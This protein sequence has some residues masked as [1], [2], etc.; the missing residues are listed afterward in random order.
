MS[1]FIILV[2][3]NAHSDRINQTALPFIKPG[4]TQPFTGIYESDSELFRVS[5]TYENGF[6]EGKEKHFYK[7]GNLAFEMQ[8]VRSVQQGVEV[9]YYEDGSKKAEIHYKDGMKDGKMTSWYDSGKLL[10]VAFFKKDHHEGIALAW[11]ENGKKRAEGHFKNGKQHG[12]EIQYYAN[13]NGNYL[14][15]INIEQ[16]REKR[17]FE[18]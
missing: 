13:E 5:S 15:N 3:L 6:K 17:L 7:S 14:K 9:H 8:Y 12:K 18:H 4:E 2:S 10:G 16:F 11:H 1:I